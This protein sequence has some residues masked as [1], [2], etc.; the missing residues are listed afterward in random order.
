MASVRKTARVLWKHRRSALCGHEEGLDRVGFAE[1]VES[2]LGPKIFKR[3]GIE[4][5]REVL[6]NEGH[7]GRKMHDILRVEGKGR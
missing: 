6:G 5:R 7:T 1:K 3:Q 4:Q 2:S